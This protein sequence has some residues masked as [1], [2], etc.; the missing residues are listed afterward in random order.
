MNRVKCFIAAFLLS[1][2][3]V[4]FLSARPLSAQAR[5]PKLDALAEEVARGIEKHKPEGAAKK[6]LVTFLVFDFPEATGGTTQLGIHLADDLSQALVLRSRKMK[7]VDR[8]D[9]RALIEQEHLDR[10]VFQQ[11][12]VALWGA[13]TLGADLAVVGTIERAS[14]AIHLKIRVIGHDPEKSFALDNGAVDWTDERH[15]WQE[16]SVPQFPP[17]NPWKDVPNANGKGYT[18][19]TCIDCPQPPYSQEARNARFSGTATVLLLIGDDGSVREVRLVQGLP[20][21]LNSQIV[22]ALKEWRFQPPTGP[23][24]KPAVVQLR[25][26]IN[27]HLL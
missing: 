1:S 27:F 4:L 16:Q 24:G 11:D 23:D 5:D 15:A 8:A 22:T 25:A 13:A 20:C 6:H 19:P 2:A 14:D 3:P 9:L 21:D 7:S 18:P 17:A 26:E 10:A 12:K